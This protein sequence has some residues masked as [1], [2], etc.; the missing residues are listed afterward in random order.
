M[1]RYEK[2]RY[3]FIFIKIGRAVFLCKQTVEFLKAYI[4]IARCTEIIL[5]ALLLRPDNSISP[6]LRITVR[7]NDAMLRG[8]GRAVIKNIKIRRWHLMALFEQTEI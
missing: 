8:R 3:I 7:R 5:V 4:K 2:H 1:Y 6:R